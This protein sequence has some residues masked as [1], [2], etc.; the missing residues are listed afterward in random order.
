M[1]KSERAAGLAFAQARGF[2]TVCAWDGNKPIASPLPA[3]RAP[4]FM[5]RVAIH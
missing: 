4:R 2:G 3:R 1:F 5:L